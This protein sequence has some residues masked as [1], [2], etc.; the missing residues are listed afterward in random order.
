M[1]LTTR[2]AAVR[3]RRR[4][5][6]LMETNPRRLRTKARMAKNDPRV[7][8]YRGWEKTFNAI[9]QSMQKALTMK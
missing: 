8:I 4:G 6:D 5:V 1:T 7:T 2:N 3:A 9:D